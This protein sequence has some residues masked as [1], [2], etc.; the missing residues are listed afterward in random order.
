MYLCRTKNRCCLQVAVVFLFSGVNNESDMAAGVC[1]KCPKC[2][3]NVVLKCKP[4]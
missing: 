2:P 3:N 1:G 4:K